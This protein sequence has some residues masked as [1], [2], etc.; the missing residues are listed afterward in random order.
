MAITPVTPSKL[1]KVEF[2]VS[3]AEGPS[4]VT[5]VTGRLEFP[6]NEEDFVSGLTVSKNFK[7][8]VDPTLTPTQFRK[9]VA[10][11]GLGAISLDPREFDAPPEVFW[12]LVDAQASFDDEAGRV[13]LIIDATVRTRNTSAVIVA[14]NFQVTTLSKI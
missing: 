10:V 9:S 7:A 5:I 8:L 14:A 4:R 2:N 3:T 12:D 11:V 6:S 13:Q 1:Q